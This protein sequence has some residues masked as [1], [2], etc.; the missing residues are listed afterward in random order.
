VGKDREGFSLAVFVCQSVEVFFPRLIALEE[1]CGRFAEGPFEMGL[2]D[3]FASCAGLFA[4][5][6]LGALDEPG[7]GGKVLDRREAVDVFDLV[8]DDEAQ[9]STDAGDGFEQGVGHRV[10]FIGHGNDAAFHPGN[11]G[12]IGLDDGKISPD[13][14]PDRGVL[15]LLSNSFP[16]LGFGDPAEIVG[17]VVL[18]PG[19]LNVSVEFGPFSHEMVSSSEQIPG[20][21]HTGRIGIRHGDHPSSEQDGNLVGVDLVVFGF[22]AVNGF[23]VEGMAQD[24]GNAVV[25]AEISDPVPCERL[26]ASD[27]CIPRQS[28]YHSGTV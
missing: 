8:E 4:I 3:L 9:D 22:A 13:H 7:I 24:K 12:I 5:G 10:M 11:D 15:K 23:H 1:E 26:S 18:T 2:A 27:G 20:G 16:V 6:L 19:V 21:S 25:F 14:F 28:R 17:E